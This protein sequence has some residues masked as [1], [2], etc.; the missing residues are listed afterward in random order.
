[1]RETNADVLSVEPR[2]AGALQG[3]DRQVIDVFGA[4]GE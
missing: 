3:I 1:M 2:V 4:S